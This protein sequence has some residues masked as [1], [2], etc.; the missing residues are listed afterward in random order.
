[1]QR[2]HRIDEVAE[3]PHAVREVMRV[4][5]R[6]DTRPTLPAHEACQTRRSHS[7]KF[8]GIVAEQDRDLEL[9]GVERL[10]AHALT[11]RGT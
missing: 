9:D 5:E 1:M 3:H 4:P 11:G 2:N 7:E 8:V 6:S 10:G